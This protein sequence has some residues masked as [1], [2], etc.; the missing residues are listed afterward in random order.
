MNVRG[1]TSDKI[2]IMTLAAQFNFSALAL[3]SLV[4]S[5]AQ[6]RCSPPTLFIDWG[7]PELCIYTVYNRIFG[8][9]PAKNTVYLP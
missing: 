2:G 8:D 5:D 6:I 4:P 9:F 1:W 7:W 3:S